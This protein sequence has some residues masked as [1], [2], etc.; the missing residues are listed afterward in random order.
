MLGVAS[1]GNTHA[2]G[3]VLS[4]APTQQTGAEEYKATATNN[5]GRSASVLPPNYSNVIRM[6]SLEEAA[7]S[8]EAPADLPAQPAKSEYANYSNI[9]DIGDYSEAKSD[10]SPDN[11][12]PS[13][14][15]RASQQPTALQ[16]FPVRDES[17]RLF[18]LLVRS[19]RVRKASFEIWRRELIDY[20][21]EYVGPLLQEGA[22]VTLEQATSFIFRDNTYNCDYS[23]P[24]SAAAQQQNV[25]GAVVSDIS[26]LY[27]AADTAMP[28]FVSF[29]ASTL[30][31]VDSID[32]DAHHED[33]IAP[34]KSP[35][36]ATEKARN[37][38]ETRSPG[39]AV[40]WL[41]DIVRGKIVCNSILQI[42]QVL[43]AISSEADRLG[44]ECGCGR[45]HRVKN[46]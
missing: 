17:K 8:K 10:T 42:M 29:L 3:N 31:S 40:S 32:F 35:D 41:Y 27:E 43:R 15:R 22:L 24:Y 44:A 37:D 1:S 21:P 39:P 19:V 46:R 16:P 18:A 6:D 33:W 2:A 4:E 38:Y 7:P 26:E 20:D 28:F 23:K 30:D 11:L 12:N 45:L 36:R 13:T 34:L 9:I 14:W 25:N 5:A